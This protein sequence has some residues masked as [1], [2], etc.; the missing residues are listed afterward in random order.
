MIASLSLAASLI[1]GPALAQDEPD[2]DSRTD[3]DREAAAARP[4]TVCRR[5]VGFTG[6]LTTTSRSW[7]FL[8]RGPV[9]PAGSPTLAM[10][11][12]VGPERSAWTVGVEASP[13][14][15]T[16]RL[17]RSE[18]SARAWLSVTSGL[19]VGTAKL[20]GGPIATAGWGRVGAGGRLLHLPWAN[21]KGVPQGIEYR[22][23]ALY[24]GG[25]EVQAY[26]LYTISA[27]TFTRKTQ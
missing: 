4:S 25:F 16:R 2:V 8:G 19:V 6:G 22:L 14:Y 26:A 27:S 3:L 18:A 7:T 17:G 15:V 1:G 21:D 12:D 20:R 23:L 11:C 5:L 10:T 13:F 9:H 24:N